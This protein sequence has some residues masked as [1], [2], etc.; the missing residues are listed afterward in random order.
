MYHTFGPING[1]SCK[2]V[3]NGGCSINVIFKSSVDR[4]SL[5]TEPHPRLFKVAWVDKTILPVK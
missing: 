2:L 1:K 3:I 5:K 4:F